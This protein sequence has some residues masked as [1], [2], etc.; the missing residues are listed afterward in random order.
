M[1][2]GRTAPE[3]G[4]RQS[5]PSW[6]EPMLA[7]LVDPRPLPRGWIYE[8]KLDGIRCL[9][10]VNAARGCATPGARLVSRN[11]VSVG[12]DFAAIAAE[13]AAR[14]RGRAVLDGELVAIDPARG[15]PSFSLLQRRRLQPRLPAL[16][17]SGLR[18]EYWLFDCLWWE[19]LDLRRLPLAQRKQVLAD[20]V[21]FGGSIVLTPCWEGGFELRY[22][23]QCSEGGEG[24]V[25]KRL[26]SRY[27]AGRSR[28]WV[29]LK[30][31]ARQEFVVGGWTDPKGSR[32]ALGA[33]LVGYYERGRLRYAGR[34]GTGFD[35]ATLTALWAE[36]IGRSR[37]DSPFDED[38]P[39]LRGVHWTEPSLVVEVAF[40]AWTP[41][42]RLRQPRFL[43]IRT[44]KPARRVQR[45]SG[46]RA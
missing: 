45:E 26:E 11:R 22:R 29:K 1:Q 13:L 23:R 24:L 12:D 40:S 3:T 43:G 36:L 44:D 39:N 42:G 21:E 5:Q 25:G 10:F 34:V 2:L 6:L 46:A 4:Y 32:A 16:R 15:V 35:R 14:A 37:R 33:L 19:G 41:D 27:T 18:L 38:T 20:A 31:S 30:C 8:P 17:R 28:D 9:A 7:T